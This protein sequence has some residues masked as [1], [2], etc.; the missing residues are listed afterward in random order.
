MKANLKEIGIILAGA[1]ILCLPVFYSG[2][3]FLT[4]DSGTYIRSGFTGVVPI[5]RPLAYGLFIKYTSM[6][7]SLWF[8][9]F[10]QSVLLAGILYLFLKSILAEKQ[11]FIF[12]FLTITAALTLFTNIGWC[13][14]QIMADTFAPVFMLAFVVLL[15]KEKLTTPNL[16]FLVFVFVLSC[17]VHLTHTL[18]AIGASALLLLFA[19]WFRRKKRAFIF[20]FKRILIV[21]ALSLFSYLSVLVINKTHKDGGGFTFS[22]GS[23]VFLM[24]HFVETGVLEKFLKANCDKPDFKDCKTCLYKD[25]LEHTLNEY[26]WWW[27]GTLY[28]TGGWDGTEKEHAFIMKKMFSDFGFATR[29]I[30]DSFIFGMKE[31]FMTQVGFDIGQMG[32]DTPPYIEIV[33]YY[34][35]ELN[36]FQSA[37]QNVGEG[38]ESK[39]KKINGINTLLILLSACGVIWYFFFEKKRGAEYFYGILFTLFIFMNAFLTAGINA[40][41]PRFQAR[42]MWLIPLFFS[43]VVLNHKEYLQNLRTKFDSDT[44]KHQR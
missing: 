5:D 35:A 40:P 37:K 13:S 3:P 44:N 4:Y 26:L 42:I 18:M 24:A 30:Y 7:T 23:H 11:K 6:G 39:L 27:N 28:K 38:L 1:L 41:C 31:L 29:N 34:P 19:M 32:K 20:P 36:T 12:L 16:I 21:S 25:S 8:T 17:I 43:V 2:Y 22:K 10:A 14:G 15:L 33:K 9:I